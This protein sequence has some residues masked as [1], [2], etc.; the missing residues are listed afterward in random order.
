MARR[1]G[2]DME[3]TRRLARRA[4]NA[5]HKAHRQLRAAHPEE[6]ERYYLEAAKEYGIKSR[7]K[8]TSA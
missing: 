1:V 2:E 5:A 3:N 8:Q 4:A 6:W 7:L